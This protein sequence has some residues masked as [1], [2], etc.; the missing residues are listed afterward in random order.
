MT[1]KFKNMIGE[2]VCFAF[3]VRGRQKG[4]GRIYGFGWFQQ[5]WMADTA[6][7]DIAASNPAFDDFSVHGDLT[8]PGTPVIVYEKPV[9]A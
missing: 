2:D 9:A 7:P 1:N 3:Q 5:P 6:L 4:T 8:P